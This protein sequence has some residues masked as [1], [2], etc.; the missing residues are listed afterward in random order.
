MVILRLFLLYVTQC[1]IIVY[2]IIRYHRRYLES[3][4]VMD[5]APKQAVECWVP[6]VGLHIVHN[7]ILELN[8][9]IKTCTCTTII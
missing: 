7:T 5:N 9:S 6:L 3:I 1:S 2:E 4:C 8:Y